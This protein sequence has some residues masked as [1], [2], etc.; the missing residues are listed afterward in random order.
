MAWAERACR[1]G[2]LRVARF[3]QEHLDC[4]EEGDIEGSEWGRHDRDK[5]K[6]FDFTGWVGNQPQI[7]MGLAN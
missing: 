5:T 7:Q 4:G 6:E 3:S 2:G 1:Q